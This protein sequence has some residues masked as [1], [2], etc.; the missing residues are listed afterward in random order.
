MEHP[1]EPSPLGDNIVGEV[2]KRG[3]PPTRWETIVL[4]DLC[5]PGSLWPSL[6]RDMRGPDCDLLDVWRCMNTKCAL[7]LEDL[8]A[9]RLAKRGAAHHRVFSIV[10]FFVCFHM[11]EWMFQKTAFSCTS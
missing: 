5:K 1:R 2:G 7:L 8:E 11:F 3:D 10:P 9:E 6:M 4:G